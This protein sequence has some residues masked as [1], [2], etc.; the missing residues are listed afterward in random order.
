MA[1]C[2]TVHTAAAFL[3]FVLGGQSTPTDPPFSCQ[4]TQVTAGPAHHFYGYIGHVGNTPWNASGRYMVL[5]RTSF[6][7]HL[8][9]PNEAADVVVLDTHNGYRV[10]KVEETR[11]WNPQQGTMLYWNPD[12]PET[13]FFFNDRD[14]ETNR[15]FCVL[16]DLGRR[17]RVREYRYED[18][19]IGNSGVAQHGGFFLAINYGR[20]ARL[21]PVTGYVGAYD[22]T[23][24]VAHP[25]DDGIF[26]IDVATG[27]KTLVVSYAQLAALLPTA[28][29]DTELFINHTLCSREDDMVYFFARG[30]WKTVHRRKPRPRRVNAPFSV[31]IDGSDLRVHAQHIGGHP[32][33]APGGRLIGHE[34]EWQVYYDVMAQRVV[35]RIGTPDILSNPEGDIA[36]SPDGAWLVNGSKDARAQENRYTIVHVET[37]AYADLP[38]VEIGAWV[39]GDLRLDPA[40]CWRHDGRAI[41]VPGLADDGTRQTFV[42]ELSPNS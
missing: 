18:V 36:L 39:S 17:E 42:F 23:E 25:A 37:G 2:T 22:R 40:P 30:G 9:A 35:G 24:G 8:P 4:V 19:S 32:E 21:R 7:D 3:A 38:P 1:L 12:A 27:E 20:L 34:G 11:A 26:K 31:R 5:L 16:Y 14:P 15:I 13:Q 29:A 28:G 6:Q 41:A 10:E 33:W